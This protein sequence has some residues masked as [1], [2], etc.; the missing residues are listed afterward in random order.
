MGEQKEK[1]ILSKTSKGFAILFAVLM[2]SFLISLG[3]SIFSVSLKEIQITTSERD[4]QIA[5]YTADSARECALYWDIKKGVFPECIGADNNGL[6]IPNLTTATLG[7]ITPVSVTCNDI[8]ATLLFHQSNLSFYA[9]TT[10]FFQ[11]SSTSSSTP[12]ADMGVA[13]NLNGS[14]ITTTITAYGHNTGI[15]GRRVERAIQQINNQ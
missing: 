2:A 3:I 4:S 15:L 5:Y 12:V 8:P 1:K 6:C 14:N 10:V 9:T 7:G 11:A 13:D